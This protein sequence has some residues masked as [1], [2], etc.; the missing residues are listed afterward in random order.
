MR[1]LLDSIEIP[2]EDLLEEDEEEDEE[3][4]EEEDFEELAAFFSLFSNFGE[5]FVCLGFG[6]VFFGGDLELKF[7]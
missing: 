1:L 4:E 5:G 6:L 7:N 2:E 3:E